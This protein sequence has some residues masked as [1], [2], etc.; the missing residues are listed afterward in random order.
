MS[1]HTLPPN[2]CLVAIVL[3]AR[4]SGDP[5]IVFHYPP[6]PGEDNSRFKNM[7]KD[8]VLNDDSTTS[9]SDEDSAGSSNEAL[10]SSHEPENNGKKDSPPD[11]YEFGSTSPEKNSGMI[12]DRRWDDLFG[13]QS[14]VLA[15]LLCPAAT[16]HKKRFEVALN[17]KVMVGRPVFARSDGS[18]KRKRNPR[19]SSSRSNMAPER[20]KKDHEETKGSRLKYSGVEET[21]FSEASGP[22]ASFD[23]HSE[24]HEEALDV[25]TTFSVEPSTKKE[26]VPDKIRSI[27]NASSIQAKPEK[28]LSMFNVVYILQPPPLEYQLRVKEMYNNVTKKLSKALKWEQSHSNYVAN[29]C[30]HIASMKKTGTEKPHLSTLYHTLI[31]QSSLAKAIATLYSSISSLRI[32]H[33][34]LT[35][36]MS[37]SLQIPIA[38]SISVLPTLLSPQLPGLWLTTAN[39]MPTDDEAQTT[40]TQLGSHFT[41]LLLSDLQSILSDVNATSSPITAALTH[42]LRVTTST[43]SFYQISQTSGIPLPD[44]QFLASH[45]IY[46]H[47]ARAIP[48]LHQRDTYI[49]S[50]NA[51][52]RNLSIAA[53][54]FA[55]VFP[56]LPSLPFILSTLSSRLRPYSNLIPS[57]DHKQAYMDILAWLMRGGWVTQLRTFAWV[58]VPPHIKEAVINAKVTNG[59]DRSPQHSETEG[60]VSA[61][62]ESD[63]ASSSYLDVPHSHPEPHRAHSRSPSPGSSTHTTLPFTQTPTTQLPTLIPNPRLAS[64]LPSRHLSAISKHVL[65]M[66]GSESQSAWDKCI[67]YFDGKHALETIPVREGWKR[68]KVKELLDGWVELG[69]LVRGRHW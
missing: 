20:T 15:K 18:W 48:P 9:S 60:S 26:S 68:K 35:S 19:R 2:P 45:L 59:S 10:K 58:R 51:D 63:N 1:A 42:Y 49:V 6:R 17:D 7:F 50:P 31:S 69:V 61:T 52:M 12:S 66:Q 37:L 11:G 3:V 38:R 29:E 32:A 25:Q 21:D 56:A 28:P 16:G 47:R 23:S 62:D 39:S 57:K 53:S 27:S 40:G 46:W 54:T 34:S 30:A 36:S 24:A 5:F 55:K 43:K 22:D 65:Q 4:T 8:N 44:I 64:D 13:Y 14:S 33:L 67:K 41:L